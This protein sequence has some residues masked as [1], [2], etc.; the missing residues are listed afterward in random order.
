MR[1]SIHIGKYICTSTREMYM[2]RHSSV[3]RVQRV[4]EDGVGLAGQLVVMVTG[5]GT[6]RERERARVRERWRKREWMKQE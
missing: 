1:T 5:I 2:P 3:R 6:E 4:R